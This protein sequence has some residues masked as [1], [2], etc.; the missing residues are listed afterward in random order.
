MLKYGKYLYLMILLIISFVGTDLFVK[1]LKTQDPIYISIKELENE[2]KQEPIDARID[3]NYII[4][5]VNGVVLDINNSYRKMKAKNAF[6]ISELTS[7]ETRPKISIFNY[8]DKIIKRANKYKKGVSLITSSDDI[9][10]Y[11]DKEVIPYSILTTTN[12]YQNKYQYGM[13]INNDYQKYKELDNNLK[14]IHESNKYCYYSEEIYNICLKYNK[15]V[16][17]SSI[18]LNK[19]YLLNYQEISSGDIIFLE[20]DLPIEGLSFILTNIEFK[21]LQILPLSIL[22]SESR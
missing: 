22:I 19:D 10:A 20:R 21:G 12:N 2:Y 7:K 16:F 17:T 15:T 14:K 9:S 5:G 3:G 8:E 11:L 18:Y 13:R 4:P 1:H 6:L